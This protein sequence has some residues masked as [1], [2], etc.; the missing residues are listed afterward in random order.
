LEEFENR[1]MSKL[2]ERLDKLRL[3]VWRLEDGLILLLLLGMILLACL[4]IFMRN[5]FGS[6]LLW[7][8]PA[9]RVLLLW[10]ALFGA[11]VASRHDRHISIDIVSRW[12]PPL[13]RAFSKTFNSLFAGAV[14]S[15]AAFY[16]GW[17]VVDEYRY[18]SA[19]I[20]GIPVW[21]F[22][23][24]MPLAFGLMALR[25]LGHAATAARALAKGGPA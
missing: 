22:E 16:A 18:S 13:L 7:A 10:T 24:V 8:D 5:A 23:S 4:Q 9:L 21:I 20:G 25:Y 3:W 12:L 15:V 2:Q 19:G 11:M 6:G 14:C 17:F 1:I